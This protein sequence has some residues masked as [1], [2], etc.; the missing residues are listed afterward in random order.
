[1]RTR[2]ATVAR[3]QLRRWLRTLPPNGRSRGA[4]RH[5]DFRRLWSG[6][7]ISQFGTQI[8]Q[9][10]LPLLAVQVLHATPLQ[11]GLLVTAS[12]LP[13]LLVGLPAG[14]WVD[15]MRRRPV[16]I[17]SDFGRA[18]LLGSIPVAALAGVLSMGQLYLVAFGAG[19]LTV[20]FDVAYMSYLPHLVGRDDL[21][22]GNSLLE[23]S[24]AVS[25]VA[26]PGASGLLVQV[27]TAPY[28]IAVD[29]VS[30]L[31][32]AS[33]ITAIRKREP[34]PPRSA[35]RH[36]G[37]EI[38]EGLRFVLGHRLLRAIVGCTAT[39]NLFFTTVEAVYVILLARELGLSAG[40]IG[41]FFSIAATGGL[42]GAAVVGRVAARIGQGPAM[43]ASV[44]LAGV[45]GLAAPLVQR[46]WL[47]WA[48]AA[49]AAL[50][51][52]A[53]VVYNIIQVSFR[54][55]L[56]PDR[57]LGRMNATI[58]FIVW[59]T[60]PLGGLLG[61]TLGSWIGVRP[62]V[63][64]GAIGGL[65]PLLWLL[66]SPLPRIRQLPTPEPEPETEPERATR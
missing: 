21:V 40:T 32:S 57:M 7:T 5:R 24:V 11:V 49:T 36:L 64:V 42:L 34:V 30:F 23:G 19:L 26:G 2:A 12:M 22:S 25:R 55:R 45:L 17:A 10:A 6:Q 37:R 46:G 63:W 39:A 14:V 50:E 52:A 58:R 28:A 20:F 59:G 43:V 29:A 31:W 27:L 47:L 35:D 44:L 62:A 51:S 16:L 4:W 54:Q 53:I 9:L 61:G 38:V 1:M 8:S 41:V 18:V 65:F 3:V 66:A 60:I 13:F 56:C 48:V 15:R 33:W